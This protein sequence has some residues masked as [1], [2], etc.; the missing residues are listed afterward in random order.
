MLELGQVGGGAQLVEDVVVTLLR[1]L[2]DDPGFLQ[3]VGA[4]VRADDRVRF[5][6][7]DLQVLAEAAAVVVPRRLRVADR[8][9]VQT[10]LDS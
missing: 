7:A 9:R 2:E 8:L 3:Q 6:E 4:H 5:A 10:E 1:S